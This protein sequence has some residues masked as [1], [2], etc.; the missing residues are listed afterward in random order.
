MLLK[1]Y[2]KKF[3]AKKRILFGA[4]LLIITYLFIV[5]NQPI[6]AL[7]MVFAFFITLGLY[8]FSG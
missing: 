3:D 4:L 5:L 2:M 8:K 1:K 7:I 6:A